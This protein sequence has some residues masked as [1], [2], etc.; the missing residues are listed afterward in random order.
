[1][2]GG[3]GNTRAGGGIRTGARSG[4]GRRREGGAVVQVRARSGLGDRHEVAP[5]GLAGDIQ[6]AGGWGSLQSVRRYAGEDRER[7]RQAVNRL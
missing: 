4:K 3:I 7:Q 6:E 5:G 2:G 1:M